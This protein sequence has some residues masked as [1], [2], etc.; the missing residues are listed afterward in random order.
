MGENLAPYVQQ[1]QGVGNNVVG[2]QQQS[3]GAPNLGLLGALSSGLNI[4]GGAISGNPPGGNPQVF[5]PPPATP[6]N[7][8][9]TTT[10][11]TTTTTPTPGPIPNFEEQLANSSLFAGMK[12]DLGNLTKRVESQEHAVGEIK[13][14]TS[15]LLSQNERILAQ[16]SA[17]HNPGA[18]AP[19]QHVAPPGGAPAA[20]VPI[21][22]ITA[23]NPEGGGRDGYNTILAECNNGA[24]KGL[25][26]NAYPRDGI[27]YHVGTGQ[28]DNLG[29][30]L[31][32]RPDRIQVNFTEGWAT[33]KD[34][35]D[36]VVSLKTPVQWRTKFGHLELSQQIID[37]NVDRFDIKLTLAHILDGDLTDSKASAT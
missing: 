16:L 23:R 30:L 31:G 2:G 11:T 27:I 35:I 34:V 22:P 24:L 20:A 4:G 28:L 26:D 13:E 37:L 19:Q 10:T 33:A 3:T 36:K 9:A 17:L 5:Q 12:T 32:I 14:N 1:G 6:P 21:A 29:A 15:L 25:L 7:S 8:S 18:A